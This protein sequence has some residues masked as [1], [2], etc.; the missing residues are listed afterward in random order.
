MATAYLHL[1]YNCILV[2]FSNQ[3]GHSKLT[4]SEHSHKKRKDSLET[5][6]DISYKNTS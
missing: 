6:V 2:S 3:W 5:L 4:T 1:N